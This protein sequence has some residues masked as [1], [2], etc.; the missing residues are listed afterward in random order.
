ML[1]TA[2]ENYTS[3]VNQVSIY[4]AAFLS[5]HQ[6]DKPKAIISP[7]PFADNFDIETTQMITNYSIIDITGKTIVS[8]SSKSDLD[9][10]S[11]QLSAGIYILNLSFE[12]GQTANYKLVKK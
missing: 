9:N 1:K 2:L 3:V 10:Q 5:N 4:G 7:N 6:F 11:T 12:N 8:T